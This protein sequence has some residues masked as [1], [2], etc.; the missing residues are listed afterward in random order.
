MKILAIGDQHF[1]TENIPEVEMF[2]TKM[3]DLALI[4]RPDLIVCLGDMLHTHER[5][6]TLALNKAYEFVRM[7]SQIAL[8][9]VLVGNHDYIQN[10]QFLTENHWMNGMK[11][12]PNV[13]IVD[14]VIVQE[15]LLFLPYVPVGRFEEAIRTENVNLSEIDCI[16]CHQEFAGCKMGAILSVEGDKWPA[17]YPQI[18][19]GHVHSKQR[20]QPNVYYTGS[21]LQVAF[22]ESEDNTV[23]LVTV[24]GSFA[25]RASEASEAI[26]VVQIQEL[27]TGMPKK[28]IV[29]MSLED[30]QDFERDKQAA[31]VKLT[32]KGTTEDIKSFK[33]TAKFQEIVAS[34][35]KI[36]FKVTEQKERDDIRQDSK[37]SDFKSI[38]DEIVSASDNPY[39]LESY[40][41][42]M[43]NRDVIVLL[44]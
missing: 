37:V 12:W 27:D 11:S 38:L 24:G 33:K 42:V 14:K 28:K 9:Y 21:S 44:N 8:T 29:Y 41:L 4:H 7:L 31:E 18:V 19:S 34:G 3:K 20:P 17:E 6:H 16:F 15:N 36:A 5:V 30:V 13:V 32:L 35:T 26:E 10:Q 40:E 1:R 23:A 43:H 25:S 22:G 2:I 39:L